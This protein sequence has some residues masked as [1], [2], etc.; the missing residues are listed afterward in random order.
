M[1]FDTIKTRMQQ[2]IRSE[3]STLGCMVSVVKKEGVRAFW[4][5]STPRVI[6][7]VVSGSVSFTVYENVSRL[8]NELFRV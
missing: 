1:P 5:G 2:A 7:L 8:L 3:K 4:R 6:R